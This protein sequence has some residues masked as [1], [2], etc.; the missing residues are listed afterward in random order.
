MIS[1]KAK[2]YAAGLTVLSLLLLTAYSPSL[3]SAGGAGGRA[4]KSLLVIKGA[5]VIDGT[6]RAPLLNGVVIVEGDRIKAVFRAGEKTIPA[7]ARVIDATGKTILPGLIDAHVHSGGSAG[8][9]VSEIEY[10]PWRER[11]DL[12]AYLYA[13]VTTIK[14]LGDDQN[15]MLMLRG[16]E[17]AGKLVSPRIFAVGKVLTAPGGHPAATT[18][19]QAPGFVVEGAVSQVDTEEAARSVVKAQAYARVDGIKAIFEG[20]SA[21]R[22]L[23]KLKPEV[24]RAIIAEAHQA[25]LKVSVHCDTA[26]DVRDAVLFGADGIEHADQSELPDE[27]LK[28]MAERAVFYTPTLTVFDASYQRFRG[29]EA[30]YDTLTLASVIPEI[31]DGLRQARARMDEKAARQAAARMLGRR[32]TARANV[33]RAS[34]LGVRIVAGTDAGNAAVFHGAALHSELAQL[35]EAGLTPLE[36]ITAATVNASAYLGASRSLG[37]IER[38]KLADLVVVDG[39]PSADIG[40]TRKIWTVIKGGQE[41]DRQNLFLEPPIRPVLPAQPLVDDFEDGDLINSWQGRWAALD[42]RIAGGTSESKIEVAP[43]GSARSRHAL[44]ITGRV[45]N[46]FQWGPFAGAVLH[47]GQDD[48][49]FFDLSKFTG[50]QF[51][52][53]GGGKPYKVAFN[54][55]A[56]RDYDDFFHEVTIGTDWQLVKVPFSVLKQAGFGKRVDWNPREV[57]SVSFFTSGGPSDHF[58]LYLDDVSF[59]R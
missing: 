7:G 11:R 26:Q 15:N 23:P 22:P 30:A 20:G 13:G 3:S 56:V 47:L 9:G 34:A 59:Y 57:K 51:Y 37:S 46:K 36:A 42:D 25:G 33:R 54:I 35:V 41:I 31:L 10:T 28:L 43:G 19:A 16:Q 27:T 49:T 6:G 4:Q 32:D 58:E 52:A 45:T 50:L 40:A 53:R 1:A 18:L 21:S 2:A 44:R 5:R 17:R 55:A 38:G 29:S 24:L 14:S 48:E 39:D 12:K 8:A